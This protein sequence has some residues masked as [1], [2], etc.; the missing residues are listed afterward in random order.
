VKLLLLLLLL[1][2]LLLAEV[3]LRLLDGGE[4]SRI[5]EGV[6][7]GAGEDILGKGVACSSMTSSQQS[8][9]RE[10]RLTS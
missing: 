1:L 2:M 9:C 8:F 4:E 6:E 3:E 5:E 7:G 10:S